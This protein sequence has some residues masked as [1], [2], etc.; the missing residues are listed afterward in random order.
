MKLLEKSKAER[1]KPDVF[2]LK[3]RTPETICEA[4]IRIFVILYC[5]KVSLKRFIDWSKI[6]KIYEYGSIFKNY[7]IW[8]YLQWNEL[9][10]FMHTGYV[11][12]FKSGSHSWKVTW[13][14]KIGL[15]TSRYLFGASY[16]RWRT[17]TRWAAHKTAMKLSSWPL[18]WS[19]VH[20]C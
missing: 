13:T 8:V 6:C 11:Y 1:M 10:C 20:S 12:Y 4:G 2:L 17:F 9:L 3:D 7:K 5:G 16:D 19:Q 14:Q 18:Q 15:E